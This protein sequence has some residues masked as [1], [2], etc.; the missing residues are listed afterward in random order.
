MTK[1]IIFVKYIEK[2]NIYFLQL[3]IPIQNTN[4]NYVFGYDRSEWHV[5]SEKVL[6]CSYIL[7]FC[8]KNLNET[9]S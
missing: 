7:L 6:P 8:M 2:L 4:K 3:L 1:E 9:E 5:S